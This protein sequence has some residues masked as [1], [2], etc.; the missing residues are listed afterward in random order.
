[1]RSF[2]RVIGVEA[3][4]FPT[5]GSGPAMKG[6]YENKDLFDRLKDMGMCDGYLCGKAFLVCRMTYIH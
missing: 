6:I 4:F 3:M 2:S 5:G 1:V